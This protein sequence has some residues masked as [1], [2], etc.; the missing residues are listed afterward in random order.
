M[1]RA[2]RQNVPLMISPVERKFPFPRFFCDNGI[3]A[4]EAHNDLIQ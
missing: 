4:S 1:P 3:A 2:R